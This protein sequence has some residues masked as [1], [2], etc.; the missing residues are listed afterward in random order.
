MHACLSARQAAQAI[1]DGE[2]LLALEPTNAEHR[3]YLDIARGL[4]PETLPVSVIT[5]LFGGN[6]VGVEHPIDVGLRQKLSREVALLVNQ[7]HPDRKVDVL[8]LGCGA[9]LLGASLGRTEGVLVGVDLSAHM[10]GQA[11]R[12]QVYDRFHKVN[13]LDALPATPENLYHVITALDVLTYIGKLDSVIQNAYRILLPEGHFVFSCELGAESEADYTLQ[14]T[15]R[16]LH[17]LSYLQ[18][19]LQKAGFEHAAFEHRVLR[20]EAGQ[21]VEGVLVVARKSPLKV[22]Q[23][24]SRRKQRAIL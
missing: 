19:L 22:I 11:F 1:Q 17:R 20:H 9:G 23:G 4:T 2:A 24:G 16:Y 18:R 7:W 5:S 13:L 15:H 14:S 21:P 6:A 3:F 12:H 10:I 8:D